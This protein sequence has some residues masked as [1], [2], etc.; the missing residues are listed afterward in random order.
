MFG[1]GT[2]GQGTTGEQAA[3][4][5]RQLGPTEGGL[6]YAAVVAGVASLQQQSGPH[7]S[8]AKGSTPI[9][10]D[11][12]PE[13]ANRRMSLVDM[14]GP[15]CGMPEGATTSAKM[16]P[17]S[18]AVPPGERHNKTPVLVTGVVDTRSFLA[19]LRGSIKSGLSAQL[20]GD[21]LMIVP[22]TAEGFRATVSALRSLDGNKGVSFHTFFHTF[23]LPEDRC[24]RLLLKNVGRNTPEEVVHEELEILGILV[25]GVMQLRSGRR[26][27]E[28][29]QARPLALHFIVSIA[30]GPEVAKVRALTKLCGLR[31]SVETYVA[32]KGP[33]QSKRCQHFGH[34]QRHCGYAPRCVACGEAHLSGECST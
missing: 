5:S 33:L 17:S 9:E 26:D 16:D 10:P 4:C 3:H 2:E 29:A 6:A 20:K 1:D 27:Q 12:S 25:Q 23:S 24:V 13:A 30:R 7:K 15:L 8:P 34:S 22:Q 18:I 31:I 28:K 21:K 32:P 11:A 14:S 19:W